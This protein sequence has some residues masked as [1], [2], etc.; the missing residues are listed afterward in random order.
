MIKILIEPESSLIKQYSALIA[1]EGLELEFTSSAIEKIAD[2]ATNVNSEV[3]DIG[4]RRL[5]TILENLL[6]DISFNASDMAK[7]KIIID[8]QFVEKQLS[9]I[10][11][12]I[13]LVKFIL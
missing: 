8:E 5:H 6:E 13:D 4:A 12:N 9:Q 3:E 1:T 11:K 2:Y 7:Q 10:V